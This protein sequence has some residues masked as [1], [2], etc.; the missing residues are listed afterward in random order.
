MP[1]VT[2]RGDSTYSV[3]GV[4][5]TVLFDTEKAN[6]KPSAAVSFQQIMASIGQRYA[7]RQVRVMGFANS[8]GGKNYNREL[9][10]KSAE[11][12]ENYLVNTG[13]MWRA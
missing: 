7:T 4:D 6:I 10:E 8:R 3:Y 12:V 9:N 11:A 13:K 1:G 2:V 5:E